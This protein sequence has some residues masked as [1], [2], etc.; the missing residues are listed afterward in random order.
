MLRWPQVGRDRA[1]VR[2]GQVAGGRDG[3]VHGAQARARALQLRRVRRAVEAAV[4]VLVHGRRQHDLPVRP[5]LYILQTYF[6]SDLA[7]L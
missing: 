7:Y 2:R 6:L 5:I 3:R 4:Q 1:A